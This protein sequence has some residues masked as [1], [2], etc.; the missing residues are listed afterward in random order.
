MES[1]TAGRNDVI[2]F[3]SIENGHQLGFHMFGIRNKTQEGP[4]S[5][6]LATE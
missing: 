3:C 4:H 1:Y 2:N 6:S 5:C